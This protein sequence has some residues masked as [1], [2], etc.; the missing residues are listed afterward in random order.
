MEFRNDAEFEQYATVRVI[1]TQHGI[2]SI[3]AILS[4]PAFRPSSPVE[5]EL[6]VQFF[7]LDVRVVALHFLAEILNML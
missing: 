6:F 3:N 5:I 7:V 4:K 2:S 1:P